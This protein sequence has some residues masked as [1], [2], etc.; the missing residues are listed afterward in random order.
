MTATEAMVAFD[1]A[2]DEV[3]AINWRTVDVSAAAPCTDFVIDATQGHV[4]VIAETR[5]E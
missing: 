3:G 4:L 1:L 2:I 5:L